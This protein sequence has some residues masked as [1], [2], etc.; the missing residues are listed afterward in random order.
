M[1]SFDQFSNIV[2]SE[3]SERRCC[4]VNGQSYH[5]DTPLGLYVVK[6]DSLV[7]MGEVSD[8]VSSKE[9]TLEELE[10]LVEKNESEEQL[11]WDFDRDLIS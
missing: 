5:A 11:E 3:A 9:V 8:H 2:L 1:I 10:E 4:F 6:G 7:L